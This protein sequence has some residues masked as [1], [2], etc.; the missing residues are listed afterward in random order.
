MLERIVTGGQTGV[1]RA[2][3]DVALRLGVPCGGYCPKGRLAEDGPISPAYPL[4]ETPAAE[5]R[6][7]TL[8]NVRHSDGTLILTV[9][10]PAG[11][12]AL[13]E[14]YARTE[15]RPF[16]VVDLGEDA[17]AASAAA[18]IQ[19]RGI[20]TL[21]VAGPRESTVPGVYALAAA[22]LEALYALA[23]RPE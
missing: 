17:P 11:G 5:Y 4:T 6:E 9:G 23:R 14:A 10:P 12:T 21:N 19:E 20:R 13:T 3:L 8:L 22:Y 1:D 15:Q 7:R 16:L 18:W 2:A